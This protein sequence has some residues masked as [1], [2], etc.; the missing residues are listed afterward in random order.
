MPEFYTIFARKNS[1]CPNLGG[2]ATALPDPPSPTPM[3]VCG[4]TPK[5]R[6]WATP[7]VY[8]HTTSFSSSFL[9]EKGIWHNQECVM[10]VIVRPCRFLRDRCHRPTKG[11]SLCP[12]LPA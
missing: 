6:H 8:R 5:L 2:G 10:V 9:N 12:S 3:I 4:C 7:V 1:F 11:R